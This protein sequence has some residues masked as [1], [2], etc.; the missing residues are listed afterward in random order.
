MRAQSLK[1]IFVLLLVS[2]SALMPVSLAGNGPKFYP[3]DPIAREPESQDAS[4]AQPWDITLFSDLLMTLFVKPG[5]PTPNV[6]AQNINTIDEVPD[7]SWFTNRIGSRPVTAEEVLRGANTMDGPSGR[8]T[9]IRPKSAGAAPGFT[10]RDEK[11]ETWFITFDPPKAPGAATAAIAVATRIFW[12]LGYY[13]AENYLTSIHPEDISVAETAQVRT[14]TGAR[15]PM[16]MSDVEEVL[17][18]S[19]RSADGSYRAIAARL[20]QGKVL[21]GFRYYGTRPDDPNDLV[22]HEHRRELRAL[23]VFGAWTNLVDLK[24]GNT[25][26]TVMEVGGRSV[27]R[28]YLQDVGSG[29][30][31]GAQGPHNYD[32]GY[33]FLYEGD[34]TL[35]RLA[36]IG[37]YL[38]PWQLIDYRELPEVGRFEGDAFDPEVWKPRIPIAAVVRARDD[39]KFW[40]A[41]RV[42]AFGDDLIRAIVREGRFRDPE[43]EKLLGD[44][45]I[46]RR[47]TI[48][49]TY[50]TKV[51][52]LVDFALGPDGVLTFENAAVRARFAE[53]PKGGYRA[54]WFAFDNASGDAR[55]IGTPST[56]DGLRLQAPA[57]LPDSGGA[58]VK[59]DV[60]AVD[61]ARPT[62]AKPVQVYFTRTGGG[63]KLVGL[64]RM[65]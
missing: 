19:A 14:Q 61:P 34:K 26:D 40:A 3:D 41:L 21:G 11:N 47:D 52:P 6:R 57:G 55:A 45:L 28:H 36:S 10:V 5:D 25:L 54:E 50:L 60:S 16:R 30:G 2:A 43:A 35:K 27:V 4:G 29:F 8:W 37:F 32:E 53:P 62:W 24:A 12:A 48:G 13:Q 63:W 18:R 42:M 39:D 44:V 22:P 31:I 49:R 23:K 9:V 38:Q 20:I 65:P 46:K 58:F 56:G 15:R 64:E 7:S 59:V 33:E 1:S 51:N 17:S